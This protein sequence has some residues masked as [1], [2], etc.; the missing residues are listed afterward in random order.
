MANAFYVIIYHL[1]STV[2][3][4]FILQVDAAEESSGKESL[5]AVEV[6]VESSSMAAVCGLHHAVLRR[7]QVQMHLYKHLLLDRDTWR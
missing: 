4:F 1:N 5:T 2:K 6:Q 7:L 3:C